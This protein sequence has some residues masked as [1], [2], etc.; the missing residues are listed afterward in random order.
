[1]R[2]PA[3]EEVRVEWPAAWSLAM[4]HRLTLYDAAYLA[5]ASQW[6]PSRARRLSD[7]VEPAAF[8]DD[9]QSPTA[10]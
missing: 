3:T 5:L 10:S 2:T 1:M 9:R 7:F 4:D 6:R 8:R